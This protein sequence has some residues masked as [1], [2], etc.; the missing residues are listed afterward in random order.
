MYWGV[1]QSLGRFGWELMEMVGR[2]VFGTCFV[3]T[4]NP[5]LPESNGRGCHGTC[6]VRVGAK[7]VVRMGDW[8]D[9]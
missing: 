9:L 8:I 1:R 4:C 7:A 3:R 6:S 2:D 5:I